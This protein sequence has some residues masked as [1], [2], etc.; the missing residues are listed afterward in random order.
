MNAYLGL[1]PKLKESG[2]VSRM[3]HINRA[4]RK[5][6]RTLLTQSLIQVVSASPYLASYYKNVKERR[7]AGRGRIAL[8]RKLCAIM[9]RM[10]LTG[11]Q[12]R[13]V[14]IALYEKKV[15]QYDRIIKNL[16]E[17]KRSA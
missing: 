14:N 9:R 17:E 5:T 13:E 7:G 4:S 8:I 10:L 3:G 6:T 12:F 16:E 1:V 11:E 2:D 15:R